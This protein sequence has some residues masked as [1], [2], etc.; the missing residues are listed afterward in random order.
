MVLGESCLK[1]IIKK[2]SGQHIVPFAGEFRGLGNDV[3]VVCPC[4]G[5]AATEFS[6]Y[7]TYPS[8]QHLQIPC[9]WI[10]YPVSTA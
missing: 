3:G 6:A 5:A 8:P 10:L 1:N 9:E 4:P 7:A 2:R